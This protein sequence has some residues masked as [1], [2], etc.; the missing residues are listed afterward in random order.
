MA[1]IDPNI[2]AILDEHRREL[3]LFAT[4][5]DNQERRA[6]LRLA[7]E[8]KS[9]FIQ[10]QKDKISVCDGSSLRSVREWLRLI[11][12]AARRVPQG[13][14][15]D[16]YIVTLMKTTATEDLLDEI[17]VHLRAAQNP[18]TQLQLR[19]HLNDAFLGPDETS[20]LRDELKAIS[21]SPREEVPRFNRRFL[22][23]SEHAYPLPHDEET[24]EMLTDQ[25]LGALS[26]GRIKDA[27]FNHNPRLV[28]LAD[29]TAVSADEWSKQRRRT[30]I[31]RE[32]ARRDEPMEVDM[33]TTSSDPPIRETLAAL[34]SGVRAVQAEVKTLRNA[35]PP[36]DSPA[37]PQSTQQRKKG[38][39][40][41]CGKPGHYQQDCRK[42]RRDGA[43]TSSAPK[44][45]SN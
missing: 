12:A 30:R 1:A 44:K 11:T 41:Y 29:A 27:C 28:T 8:N 38:N 23:A 25:Y 9:K 37:P 3:T 18:V 16:D 20:M 32:R 19:D 26:T 14:D 31:Q 21:Q 34:A 33:L 42:R 4:N 43:P 2:Q 22:K 36:R 13:Q 10:E 40:W 39:C 24:E 7:S 35:Q 5:C 6:N 45:T 15:V 17:E